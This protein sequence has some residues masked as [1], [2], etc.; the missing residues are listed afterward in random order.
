MTGVDNLTITLAPVR[1]VRHVNLNQPSMQM[2]SMY[3]NDIESTLECD[4][5]TDT[6]CI[7]R[8]TLI[9]NDYDRPVTVY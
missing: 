2:H 9:L 8:H 1:S 5:Y 3:S 4:T 6:C 7:G